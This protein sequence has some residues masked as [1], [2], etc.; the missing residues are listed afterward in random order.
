MA[1]ESRS[2]AASIDPAK[3]RKF[4]PEMSGKA[5]KN[6]RLKNI[7]VLF[8]L[9]FLCSLDALAQTSR[10][11][12]L[13]L[14]ANAAQ[15][16]NPITVDAKTFSFKTGF[17]G[18]RAAYGGEKWGR[19]HLQYGVAYLPSQSASFHDANL[20]GAISAQSIGYGYTYPIEFEGTPFSLDLSIDNVTTEHSGN[21]FTGTHNSNNVNAS[22][23]ATSD[24]TRSSVAL[25]YALDEETIITL[26][27]GALKWEIDAAASGKRTDMNVT[28]KT[29]IKASGNDLF[30]FVESSFPLAGRP[31]KLGYRRSNLDT[32]VSNTLNEIY[33]EV[34]GDFF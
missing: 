14:I 22:V 6:M 24:F 28:F 31:V 11:F 23:D 17:V 15:A 1:L 4:I 7:P 16:A 19:V 18:L 2:C 32:G 10:G 33:V 12:D 3:G 27:A 26:G 5:D 9:V 13:D 34:S 20:S 29:D 21:D 25:N 30:Y 8:S